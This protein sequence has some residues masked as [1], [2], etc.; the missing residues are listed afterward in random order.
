MLIYSRLFFSEDQTLWS[1]FQTLLS[2]K[3]AKTIIATGYTMAWL[4]Y[5]Y[6]QQF[7]QSLFPCTDMKSTRFV[8][9]RE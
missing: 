4:V 2:M 1:V 6:A 3:K 8:T 9:F 5:N 7:A